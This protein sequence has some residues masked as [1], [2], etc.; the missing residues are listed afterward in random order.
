[1][2]VIILTEYDTKYYGVKIGNKDLIK[3]QVFKKYI[4]IM[5]IVYYV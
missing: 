5:K 3:V 2:P 4:L 1:M